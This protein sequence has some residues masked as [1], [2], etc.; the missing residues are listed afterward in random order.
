ML[1][2]GSHGGRFQYTSSAIGVDCQPI[3]LSIR[4]ELLDQP[5]KSKSLQSLLALVFGDLRHAIRRKRVPIIALPRTELRNQSNL[6]ANPKSRYKRRDTR[7]PFAMTGDTNRQP[8]LC[9]ALHY[10]L[11]P[12]FHN[13]ST[14]RT[15]NRSGVRWILMPKNTLPSRANNHQTNAQ[16]CNS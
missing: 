13:G 2:Y 16:R 1:L 6:V 14:G 4:Q 7:N 11:P 12:V 5:T 3:P 9:I 15:G 8:S 10:K